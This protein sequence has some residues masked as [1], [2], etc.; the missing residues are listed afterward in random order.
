MTF[1]INPEFPV[2]GIR[3]KVYKFMSDAGFSTTFGDKLFA[4]AD[5]LKARVYGSGS[6]VCLDRGDECLYDGPIGPGFTDA[7]KKVRV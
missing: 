6:Q 7:L 1:K 5:G 4:S 3:D 2:G